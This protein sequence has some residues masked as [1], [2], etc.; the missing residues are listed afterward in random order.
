MT[1]L[2][3]LSERVNGLT[4]I[5]ADQDDRESIALQL[6]SYVKKT[7]DIEML[8]KLECMETQTRYDYLNEWRN[9]ELDADKI[10]NR[11]SDS[12]N[13]VERV[14]WMYIL[15]GIKHGPRGEDVTQSWVQQKVQAQVKAGRSPYLIVRAVE[16]KY[17]LA[18]GVKW[19]RQ[20]HLRSKFKYSGNFLLNEEGTV[21]MVF[22]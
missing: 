19:E 9:D 2:R 8:I 17:H 15:N 11:K 10:F 7:N 18:L 22:L 20:A 14:Y 4:W 16:K 21:Q 5:F 12:T 13:W 1:T 6:H 3:T